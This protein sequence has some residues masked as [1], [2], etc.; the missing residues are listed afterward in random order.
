MRM[1]AREREQLIGISSLLTPC[2]ILGTELRPSGLAAGILTWWATWS[3]SGFKW[4]DI[5]LERKHLSSL[6]LISISLSLNFCS[7]L[8]RTV[9]KNKIEKSISSIQGMLNGTLP[10]CAQPPWPEKG[11][12]LAVSQERMFRSVSPWNSHSSF[13]HS[14]SYHIPLEFNGLALEEVI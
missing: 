5:R 11:L 13:R 14:T 10:A 9:L 2:G 8:K 1:R 7:H 4:V 12:S 3:S 6:I